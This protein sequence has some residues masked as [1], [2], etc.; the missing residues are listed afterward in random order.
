VLW[1]PSLL[2][3]PGTI[4]LNHGSPIW[5]HTV[6]LVMGW[7]LVAIT[8]HASAIDRRLRGKAPRWCGATI[9][10][11]CPCRLTN[12]D[13]SRSSV[14]W[15]CR[16]ASSGTIGCLAARHVGEV[17]RLVEVSANIY[18]HFRTQCE[19]IKTYLTLKA[20]QSSGTPTAEASNR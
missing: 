11:G 20:S 5:V 7:C 18:K 10:I 13:M 19:G 17:L 9:W 2:A 1:P 12:G 6:E 15:S 4:L 8:G 14:P 3:T 16:R